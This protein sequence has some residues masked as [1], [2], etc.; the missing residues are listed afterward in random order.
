VTPATVW[1][2]VSALA[3][4]AGAIAAWWYVR[5][6]HRLWQATRD[7][8]QMLTKTRETEL[9]QQLILDYDRLRDSIAFIQSYYM[10]CACSGPQ[11]PIK[12]FAEEMMLDFHGGV[13][14]T[15]AHNL[16][17]HRHRVSRFFVRT[18]KLI[19]ADYLSEDVLVQALDRRA[20][21]T[22]SWNSSTDWTKRKRVHTTSPM[23]GN[24][25]G[26]C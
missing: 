17:D 10:D 25:M 13:G 26:T 2:A 8:V 20:I 7:Q 24:F 14:D 12:R 23:I 4:V 6:T 3:T 22:C 11:D 19:R 9:M 21:K 5:L 15:N 16:D 18:R 1:S